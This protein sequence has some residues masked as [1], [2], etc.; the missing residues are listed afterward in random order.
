MIL[1]VDFDG[2]L[3]SDKWPK[4]GDPDESL[5]FALRLARANGHK[6]IFNTC[7]SGDHEK[8][9]VAFIK[10]CGLEFDAVN[11]NINTSYQGLPDC[12]KIF[13]DFYYDDR[14]FNWDRNEAIEHITSLPAWGHQKNQKGSE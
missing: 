5:I 12:R 14:S 1:S 3:V 10:K 7:R 8:Q 6:I 9:A 11:E 2:T 4:I 13:A